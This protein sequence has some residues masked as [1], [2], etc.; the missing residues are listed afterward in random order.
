MKK[1]FKKTTST[2][3]ALAVSFQTASINITNAIKANA[4]N[5]NPTYTVYGDLNSDKEIDV[6]DLVHMR[7]NIQ[8]EHASD[9]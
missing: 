8:A 9:S 1:I 4:E 3:L 5:T 6:F 2:I 7:K